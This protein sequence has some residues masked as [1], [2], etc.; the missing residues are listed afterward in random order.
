MFFRELCSSLDTLPSVSWTS[1]KPISE[2]QALFTED[3]QEDSSGDE[4]VPGIGD[5]EGEKEDEV[6][7]EINWYLNCPKFMIIFLE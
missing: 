3:L 4:Y 2:V 1:P 7:I 6:S 5:E